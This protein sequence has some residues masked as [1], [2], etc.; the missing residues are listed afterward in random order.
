MNKKAKGEGYDSMLRKWYTPWPE[1]ASWRDDVNREN[2]MAVDEG[3][4][5]WIERLF[6]A[7]QIEGGSC[8]FFRG[9]SRLFVAITAV[10]GEPHNFILISAMAL[11]YSPR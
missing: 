10:A 2:P 4:D 3:P 11:R 9:F 1:H 7:C 6:R 5:N 8:L